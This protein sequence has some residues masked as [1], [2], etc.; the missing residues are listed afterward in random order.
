MPG[1]WLFIDISHVKS[2]SY[3]SSQY[4]L[5]A[6]NDA[7]DFS[8][9]LFLKMKDQM[10]KA[11]I[12]LIQELKDSENIIVKMIQCNNLGENITFQAAA[13]EEGLGLHFEFT[14]H[15]TPQQNGHIECKFATLFGRRVQSMLN[16]AGLTGKH[17]DLCQ[18]LWAEF[19]DTATKIEIWPPRST[20]THHLAIFS[21]KTQCSPTASMFLERSLLST[22]CRS[23]TASWQ[24]KENT[25]CL[26]AM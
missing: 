23:C 7:T 9:S 24:T 18:G 11:M 5:L 22:M 10:S 16:S 25:A 17:K 15:Q 6:V 3:S 12:S 21:S 8:F 2:H 19:A 13:K 20:R 26:S 1:K 4:W 14:A